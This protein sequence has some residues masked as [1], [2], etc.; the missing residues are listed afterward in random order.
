MSHSANDRFAARIRI[1]EEHIR[2][3]NDH[4]LDGV[5]STFGDT[6]LYE[7]EAWDERH[8]GREA[9]RRYYE[10]LLSAL[11]DLRIDVQQRHVAEQA[12]ILE[13]LITG[14]HE[15]AWRGLPPTGRRVIFPLT[16]VYT[17]TKDDKLAGE[18]TYY[19]RA[20]VFRQLGLY[21]EPTTPAGRIITA[22]T[23]PLTI[24]RAFGRK[25][26]RSRP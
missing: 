9:V 21:H 19:D 11:P 7:E 25:L 17:F 3:E 16:A 20:T 8:E 15:R 24:A 18:R 23:H 14:T 13:V 22:L 5:L 26:L 6:A 12:V 10:G 2:H 1:V 4:D